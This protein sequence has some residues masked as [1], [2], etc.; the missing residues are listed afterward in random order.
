MPT[1]I[2]SNARTMQLSYWDQGDCKTHKSKKI[3]QHRTLF[4]NKFN[5][6]YY[7]S[8]ALSS[9]ATAPQRDLFKVA[10]PTYIYNCFL[11]H[12]LGFPDC[13]LPQ[14][15]WRPL[16]TNKNNVRKLSLGCKITLKNGYIPDFRGYLR[17][18]AACKWIQMSKKSFH[19]GNECYLCW[20]K[21][22]A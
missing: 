13:I 9:V 7:Q 3:L 12:P 4:S 11:Y 16:Q 1:A 21:D 5:S 6:G 8:T 20:V 2:K 15:T 10:Y 17:N 14:E 18:L 19:F 22:K